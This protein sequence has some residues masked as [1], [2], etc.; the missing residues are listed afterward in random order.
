MTVRVGVL[1]NFGG[2][3]SEWDQL[4]GFM[5]AY[6]EK[7]FFVNSN[8]KSLD[9]NFADRLG[10][11]PLVVTA[12]PDL[13]VDWE[14]LK[15]LNRFDPAFV[16]VKYAPR[17]D[18]Q[19]LAG[20]LARRHTVVLT[21]MRF[22]TLS[23]LEQTVPNYREYYTYKSPYQYLDREHIP[24]GQHVCDLSGLGCP[25][26]QLC[27]LLTYNTQEPIESLELSSSGVCKF[28]CMEC[29]VPYSLRGGKISFDN[30]RMNSK[31]KGKKLKK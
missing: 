30:I 16:R 24:T 5:A 10:D 15:K 14:L 1:T 25:S 18:V 7:K 27:S 23:N 19:A 13:V 6:P 2:T 17:T 21:L 8:I 9:K 28:N 3:E 29:F 26:C 20:E 4:D 11:I 22:R 12:N 31:Q